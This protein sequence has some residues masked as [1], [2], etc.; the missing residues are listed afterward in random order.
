MR[1]FCKHGNGLFSRIRPLSD[2]KG[3]VYVVTDS[4]V[5]E[6]RMADL[7]LLGLEDTFEIRGQM[8]QFRE[9]YGILYLVGVGMEKCY[10]KRMVYASYVPFPTPDPSSDPCINLY[11]ENFYE[12]T[13]PIDKLEDPACFVLNYLWGPPMFGHNYIKSSLTVQSLD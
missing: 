12:V 6:Y 7:G 8:L 13:S 4:G 3:G 9:G 11:S 10:N 2:Y 5:A 1:G